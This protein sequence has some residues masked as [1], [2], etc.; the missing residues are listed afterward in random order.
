MSLVFSSSFP[1]DINIHLMSAVHLMSAKLSSPLKDENIDNS[2][3]KLISLLE[4][5][6]YQPCRVCIAIGDHK[7]GTPQ[8]EMA[9][10]DSL[11]VWTEGHIHFGKV[12][13]Y[14]P[15]KRLA[16]AVNIELVSVAKFNFLI[17]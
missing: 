17:K 14:P 15:F 8:G 13:K 3:D 12:H 4:G 7:L 5:I 9:Q 10:S 11:T 1:P 16:I 2:D 6:R